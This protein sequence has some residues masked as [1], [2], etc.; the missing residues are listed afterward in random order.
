[1]TVTHLQL[2]TNV[3]KP[4]ATLIISRRLYKIA[5]LDSVDAPSNAEVC[6]SNL[7]IQAFDVI[8]SMDVEKKRPCDRMDTGLSDPGGSRRTS[9]YVVLS[10]LSSGCGIDYL[11]QTT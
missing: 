5:S 2:I 3:V 4:M 1:M 10:T 11:S 8:S 7:M 9:L 6:I